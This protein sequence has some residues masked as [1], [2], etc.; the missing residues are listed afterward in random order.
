MSD[1]ERLEAQ[2]DKRKTERTKAQVLVEQTED[3]WLADYETKDVCEIELIHANLKSK[4][5]KLK[6]ERE[7]LMSEANKLLG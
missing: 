2:I 6:D 4:V 7:Q 3:K 1:I 5:V